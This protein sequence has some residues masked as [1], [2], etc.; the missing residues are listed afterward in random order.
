MQLTLALFREV[1]S[2]QILSAVR[3]VVSNLNREGNKIIDQ[4]TL[5]GQISGG[6]LGIFGYVPGMIVG[7]YAGAAANRHLTERKLFNAH[8][9]TA[10]ELNLF[11]SLQQQIGRLPNQPLPAGPPAS[12]AGPSAPAQTPHSE[13]PSEPPPESYGR[14]IWLRSENN[15]DIRA[16]RDTAVHSPTAPDTNPFA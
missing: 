12:T 13:P 14:S 16:W 8:S 6:L 11:S 1:V 10:N 3:N 5:T 9:T 2:C 15:R 7:K 4:A